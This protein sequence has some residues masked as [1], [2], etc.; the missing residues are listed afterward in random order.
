MKLIYSV[1]QRLVQPLLWLCVAGLITIIIGIVY[2]WVARPARTPLTQELYGGV[3]YTRQILDEP[4]HLILHIVEIDRT[5]PDVDFLV[6]PGDPESGKDYFA[7]KTTAFLE[8]QNLQLAING[9]F[10]DPFYAFTPINYYP[11]VGD[12]VD[13]KAIAISNGEVASTAE[14][15]KPLFCVLPDEVRFERE[16]CPAGTVQAMGGSPLFL[17]DGVYNGELIARRHYFRDPEPRAIIAGDASGDTI[18][19]ILIDGRQRGYSEG[20]GLQELTPI[21]QEMG[22]VNALNLDGG[23]SVTLAIE[24]PATGETEILNSPV[25]TRIPLRERPIANHIGIFADSAEGKR[26]TVTGKK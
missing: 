17:V 5:D 4:R 25:H 7:R 8:E 11:R 1:G 6:T 13:A 19:F 14:H 22:V 20:I 16:A 18:W 10:F 12:P 3:T 9:D 15:D 21:L 2:I 26:P 24:N 23:G